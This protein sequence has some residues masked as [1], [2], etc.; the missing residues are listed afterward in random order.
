MRGDEEVGDVGSVDFS[1]D[2]V[3]AA[4]G[5]RVFE[6]SSAIGCEPDETE[7]GSVEGWVGG[8]Q[9]VDQQ[10]GFG[11]LGDRGQVE[12]RVWGVADSDD[13]FGVKS[14]GSDEIV[15]G[16]GRSFRGSEGSNVDDRS[17]KNPA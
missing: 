8:A 11:D 5:A 12:R 13:G 9:V 4:G 6:D 2:S 10:V 7:D 15:V 3:V 14:C 1:S 17:L 16:G